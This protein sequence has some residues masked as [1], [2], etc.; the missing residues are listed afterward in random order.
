MEPSK[1]VSR[2]A[3]IAARKELM[4]KEKEFTRQ[5]DAL[6]AARRALPRVRVDKVYAF[7]GEAGRVTLPELFDGKRQLLVYHFMFDP[8]WEQGCKSCS[9][10]ADNF[11][12]S[13]VHLRA[14]DTAFVAVS[15]APLAKLHAFRARMG[16]TFP[17]LSS[18]ESDFNYDFG[19]SFRSADEGK[20]AYNFGTM[21]GAGEAPGLSAFLREGDDV[22]H[23]YSTY[24]RGLDLL[25]GTYN[26]LDL[27]ALGRQEA[28]LPYGMAWVRHHDRY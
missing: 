13:V 6:S 26:Y 9:L 25:I 1:V 14:R 22:L 21:D 5:R 7:E 28:D 19:V 24:S 27:T 11:D 18:L 20:G 2:D 15:R 16:W 4:Q 23:T 3:W 8:S 12:A 10:L 17:W